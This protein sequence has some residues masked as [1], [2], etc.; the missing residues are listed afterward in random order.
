MAHHEY[1]PPHRP[2][3][4]DHEWSSDN[5]ITED[6]IAETFDQCPH[7]GTYIVQYNGS[8]SCKP[9]KQ[10]HNL[11]REELEHR[12]ETTPFPDDDPVLVR[13]HKTYNTYAYHEPDSDDTPLCSVSADQSFLTRTREQ[14]H[15]QLLAPCQRCERIRQNREADQ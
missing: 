11:N 2:A 1:E 7:C 15:D 4:D 13:E 10:F 5:E 6:E 12:I 8:H 3:T 9:A 14:A